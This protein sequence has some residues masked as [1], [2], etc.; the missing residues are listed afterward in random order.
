MTSETF[1][2][3]VLL[4]QCKVTE[5]YC[6]EVPQRKLLLKTKN[7]HTD[8]R[9]VSGKKHYNDGR[10]ALEKLT[11]LFNNYQ[12]FTFM[13]AKHVLVAFAL[14]GMATVA[15]QS[16]ER[17]DTVEG[18]ATKLELTRTTP[19]VKAILEK[20]RPAD[21]NA[22]PTPKFALHT[23]DNK[24]IMTIGGQIN[25]IMGFDIGNNL[26]S[27]PDAGSGFVTSAIPVPARPG[28]KGDFFL[29]PLNG[30][31]DL[32]VVGFGGTPDEITAYLK[33]GTNGI[34]TSIVLKDA[35]ITYRNFTAG[36][37]LSMLQD[38][39]ACQPPTI[40]PEG[41]SGEVS[42]ASYELSYK[43][44]SYN[45]FR[46]AVGLDIPT[47]Y[48]SNGYYRGKDYPQFDGVQ[49]ANYADAENIIPDI[50]AW[51][52]YSFSQWNRVRVSGILRTFAYRDLLS[53]KTR[54]T[55]GWGAMLSGNLSPD[56]KIIFYYQVM[57]GKGIGNYIQDIAGHP[58]S[59]IPDDSRPGHMSAS[60]M[61]GANVG[62][63]Y[64]PTS[65]LQF[66][67]M[68]SEAR[69]W[70][71]GAYS[72]ALSESQNYKY[73]LYGAVNCFYTFNSWLQWGIEYLWGHRQTWNHQGAHDNR[74][75]TQVTFTF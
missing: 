67:A 68:F 21:A 26:Y 71:V 50:P 40:D 16:A 70:D 51:V 59:F 27:Q 4:P 43:S 52:E 9:T 3:G 62:I 19:A 11:Q 15:A 41:P 55:V 47:Y 28:K 65:K 63:S 17:T 10:K 46:Y 5:E 6:P 35:Y 25:P 53:D 38:D 54:H 64:N 66:N 61:L 8:N 29:N 56:P 23:S 49:V 22:I 12:T 57:Y 60:P 37:K 58:V 48:S 14:P 20:S 1:R 36:L 13:K 31:V 24:F 7:R 73:A 30:M 44:P 45:G 34:N 74:I 2:C 39:Y 18:T 69:I 32:Q 42:T 75:Q 33:V 72:N